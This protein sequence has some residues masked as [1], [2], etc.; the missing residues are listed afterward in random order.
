[1]FENKKHL[2]WAHSVKE[3]KELADY[4]LEHQDEARE[5]AENGFKL[6]QGAHTYRHRMKDL[7]Q[8]LQL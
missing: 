5:I 2:V 4:Y 8:R 1:M 3:M 6:V 7:C